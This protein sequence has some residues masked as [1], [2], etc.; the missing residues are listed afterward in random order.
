MICIESNEKVFERVLLRYGTI[1]SDKEFSGDNF[2]RIREIAIDGKKYLHY[3]VNGEIKDIVYL[4]EVQTYRFYFSRYQKELHRIFQNM[5]DV[6]IKT[7]ADEI[8]VAKMGGGMSFLSKL[9]WKDKY[10][11]FADNREAEFTQVCVEKG[12]K[13]NFKDA[14]LVAEVIGTE[15]E[16]LQKISRR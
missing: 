1:L 3:M 16:I 15:E 8:P 9:G 7:K 4:G 12:E 2:I 5:L 13:C 14:V 10:I 6:G 11:K